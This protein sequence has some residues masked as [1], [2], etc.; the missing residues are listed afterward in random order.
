LS[1]F[2]YAPVTYTDGHVLFSKGDKPDFFYM[3]VHGSVK[4]IDPDRDTQIALLKAGDS[5]G[6]QS[7]LSDGLRSASATAIGEIACIEIPAQVAKRILNNEPGR[8]KVI[9]QALVMQLHMRNA[10]AGR[11]EAFHL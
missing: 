2:Q 10:I 7:I 6:E 1:L 4:I 5:F 3:L 8:I 9:L 11:R